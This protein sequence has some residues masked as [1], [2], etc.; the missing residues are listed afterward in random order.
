MTA[1]HTAA[2]A[3]PEHLVALD[4]DGT[5]ADGG[6][7]PD[8]TVAAVQGVVAAGHHVV[9]ATGRS[10]VGVAPVIKRL[11]LRSGRVICSNGAVTARINGRRL[12]VEDVVSFDAGPAMRRVCA[13]IPDV[14]MATEVL[15]K[16]YRVNVRFPDQL[17]GGR[18]YTVW[19]ERDLWAVPTTRA[20]VFA[21]DVASMA[22]ELRRFDATATPGSTVPGGWLDLT[23]PNLSKATAL[24]A[25]RRRVLVAPEHTV[26]VGDGHNDLPM[27][28]WAARA[29]AMGNATA[30]VRA[31]ADE[32]CGSV[33]EHGAAHVLREIAEL[34]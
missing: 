10:L 12:V 16:G 20:V 30:E 24:E 26:A 21:P 23:A 7:I 28:E 27:L 25:V 2:L 15:G 33:A 34:S 13:A 14:L 11:G 8:V 31:T 6:V 1:S 9:L 19:R 3:A 17:L 22:H 29:V 5:L 18:Q 32:V 4:I